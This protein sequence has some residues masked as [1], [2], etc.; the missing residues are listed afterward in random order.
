[1]ERMVVLLEGDVDLGEKRRVTVTS[2]RPMM[3]PPVL[4]LRQWINSNN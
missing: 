2:L 4:T 1:M 3:Q